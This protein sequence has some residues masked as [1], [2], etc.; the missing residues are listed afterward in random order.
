M[1]PYVKAGLITAG[2]IV[3]I[4]TYLLGMYVEKLNVQKE[5]LNMDP[6]HIVSVL[7]GA[8]LILI[9]LRIKT[10]K[11]IEPENSAK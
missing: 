9:G 10:K 7:L 11:E 1:K 2:L 8:S 5:S 6:I 3:L 4:S